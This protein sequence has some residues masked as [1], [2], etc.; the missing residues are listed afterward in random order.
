M[1][2]YHM[3]RN[4]AT[5]TNHVWTGLFDVAIDPS[6]CTN[7]KARKFTPCKTVGTILT[8]VWGR[9][10]VLREEKKRRQGRLHQQGAHIRKIDENR[11]SRMNTWVQTRGK[12]INVLVKMYRMWD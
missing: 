7:N 6:S 4:E 2:I 9:W 3:M 1:R 12:K 5:Q 10:C 11:K 8:D